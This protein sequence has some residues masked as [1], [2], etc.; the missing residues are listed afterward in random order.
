[1]T[2]LLSLGSNLSDRAALLKRAV[3]E[4][5]RRIPHTSFKVAPVYETEPVDVPQ[6]FADMKF[7]NSAVA[8]ETDM[9]PVEVSDT[10]HAIEDDFGRR[11][12]VRHAPR[13][14]DIDIIAFGNVVLDTPGLTIPH[15]AAATRR[16]VLTPL[17]DICPDFVLPGQKRT[18]AQLLEALP[19][20]DACRRL[21]DA[22]ATAPALRHF[23]ASARVGIA[24][25]SGGARGLAHIGVL[26]YLREIGVR[27]SF[28]TGTS[29]GSIV[30]AAYAC[31]RLNELEKLAIESDWRFLA[32]IFGEVGLN[33]SGIFS[34]RHIERFMRSFFPVERIE[35]LDIPFA[36][37]ASDYRRNAEVVF[38]K[39]D[40]VEAIRAS[41]SIPGVFT[42]IRIRNRYLVDGALFN[43]VPVSVA[44]RMGATLV[45][46]VDVN[47]AA[48]NGIADGNHTPAKSTFERHIRR[49]RE[50][51][52]EIL[53]TVPK[54]AA[55]L[56]SAKEVLDEY[57]NG[58][59]IVEV[60]MQTTRIAENKMTEA[61]LASDPPDILIQ[62]PVGDI[63][64]LDFTSAAAC[65]R[66]GYETARKQC[67]NRL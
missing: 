8:I 11:R 16:F 57:R 64:T 20:G 48:G 30:G 25:G 22:V 39:G 45:I 32:K 36:A 41:I 59:T 56:E 66:A 29:A 23:P 60:L 58:P 61:R 13:Q 7:L 43:P 38:D 15:P 46:G 12:S 33:R 4:L 63:A 31:G 28:V 44:R 65:I 54:T 37:V 19:P 67:E 27:P 1:M 49:L 55:V 21:A 10:V 53:E 9:A 5:E 18:I 50:R 47:L 14:I 34:G 3:G 24:L 17:A 2:L 62:P 6:E 42:P 26:K 35:E 52:D 40:I 51:L